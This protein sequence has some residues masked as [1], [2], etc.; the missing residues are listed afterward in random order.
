M[1]RFEEADEPEVLPGP[2]IESPG[3]L[4]KMQV[5]QGYDHVFDNPLDE[6]FTE[7]GARDKDAAVCFLFLQSLNECVC[8]V[9]KADDG[10]SHTAD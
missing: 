9:D 4:T 7:E 6:M 5:H 2:P 1:P 8:F 10:N 3:M